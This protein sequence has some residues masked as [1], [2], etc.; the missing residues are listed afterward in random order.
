MLALAPAILFSCLTAIYRGYYEGLRNMYP[1]AISEI[2]EAVCKLVIGL[3]ASWWVVKTGMEEYRSIGTVFGISAPSEEYAKSITLPFAAAGAILGVTAGSLL[4]FVILLCRH[5]RRG[6]GITKRELQSSPKPMPLNLTTRRLIKMAVPI[7]I[8]ALA[9]NIAGLVDATFLQTRIRNVMDT[10]PGVILDMYEGM[11]P[12]VNIAENTVPNFLYGCFSM[13]LTLF[14][15]FP[16]SPRRSASASC[17][18]LRRPQHRG[19]KEDI[20]RN[21]ERYVK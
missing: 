18:M 8:G 7:G 17:R 19:V 9:V 5:K 4:G 21:M 20:K 3:S 11:I 2:T 16:L 13:A 12:E 15:W 14:W 10:A 1:T 6:D